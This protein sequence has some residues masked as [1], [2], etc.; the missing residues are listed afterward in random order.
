MSSFGNL[1]L[2]VRGSELSIGDR[3]KPLTREE[4]ASTPS[5]Q[6]GIDADTEARLRWETWK[7]IIRLC[8]NLKL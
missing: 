8:Q 6:H 4:F 7:F 2:V 5:R 1:W 3:V